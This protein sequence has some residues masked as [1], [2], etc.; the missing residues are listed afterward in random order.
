MGSARGTTPLRCVRSS[1]SIAPMNSPDARRI[2]VIG[3]GLDLGQD[4]RGVDMGPSAMRY[5]GLQARLEALGFAVRD[6]GNIVAPDMAAID[7]GDPRAKYLAD[8]LRYNVRMADAVEAA[9]RAGEFPL[10]LGGDHSLAIGVLG[11]LARAAG[12][13]GAVLW[14]DAHGD[15]NTP[16]TSPSREHPRD[17]GGGRRR[18]R[19]GL[20]RYRRVAG[21]VRRRGPRRDDRRPLARQRGARGAAPL[22]DPGRDDGGDRPDRDGG[23]GRHRTRPAPRGAVGAR[24]ARHG[25]DGPAPRARRRDAGAG[26]HHLPRG[27]PDDGDGV[28]VRDDGL[29]AGGRG[30]PD[31]RRAESLRTARRRA[32]LL[33]AREAHL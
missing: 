18:T 27:A 10:V 19:P 4:R 11:G 20:V 32:R 15:L 31:P 6:E 5:A 17:A 30:E 21:A 26:R 1:R 25:R 14:I 22:A 12:A 16:D 28:R 8:I 23:R 33:G 13:P 2:R 3:A 29:A 7:Q 24:V 9:I